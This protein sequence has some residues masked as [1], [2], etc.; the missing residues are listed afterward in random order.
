GSNSSSNWSNRRGCG[1]TCKTL[2]ARFLDAR[3]SSGNLPDT[4]EVEGPGANH[5]CSCRC[6]GPGAAVSSP[7]TKITTR[8]AFKKIRAKWFAS[9]TCTQ[10]TV[11][12]HKCAKT[13]SSTRRLCQ[14]VLFP[15]SRSSLFV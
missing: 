15:A 2:C 12:S 9:N 11:I 8:K 6:V 1:G 14:A 4:D 5:H 7:P 3:H 13:N 10:P